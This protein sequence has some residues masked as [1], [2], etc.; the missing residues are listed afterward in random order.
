MKKNILLFILLVFNLTTW[1]QQKPNIIVIYA[2]DLGYGDLSCYGMSKI[3]TPNIDKLAKQG[4]Q[5]TNA[6]STSATCT[7]SR[8]GLL[9]G[10]YPW[11]QKGTGIAPG[12]ASLIIP[13]NKATLP[14]MLQKA[15]YTTAVIG[16]WHLGLGKNG[17]DWNKEI[18]PGPKEVG[19]DYSFIMP[20]TLDRVPCVYL[21]N[22]KVV[23]LDPKDPITVSY[24]EKVGNDPTGKENP[25]LL[26]M[27]PDPNQGHNETIVDSISRIGYMSGGHS[28]YWKDADIAGDITKKAISF[29]SKNAS[30]PFF[31]YFATGDIHVPRYPHS[32]FRGK[33]G[34]GLRG[35]AILQL[36]WTVGEIV[37]ALDSLKLS[38]NTLIIFSSDNGPV[39]N[40]GYM[41]KAVEML[42]SHKPAGPLRGGK[43]SAFEAGTRVPF[44]VKWP[45]SVQP[46]KKTSVLLS[47]VDLFSSLA[48]ITGQ[49]LQKEDALDSFDMSAQLTGKSKK[50]RS[51]L[52]EQGASLS[53]IQGKWKYIEP[54]NGPRVDHDVNIELGNDPK[55]QLYDLSKDIGEKINLASQYPEVVANLSALLKSSKELEITRP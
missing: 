46:D 55:P 20:A 38:Q 28:A 37:K 39:V 14:S 24:K 30:N 47:H 44:I 25:E 31:L 21:E 16:K 13:T 7:P 22:G 27:K 8:F 41:D 3:S 29:I 6:H 11:K 34:M 50:D 49:S 19:F 51:Y 17:I 5:F 48:K 9:T 40:D 1:A 2:D 33:S 26:R 52:I 35:D 18:K 32:M 53:I 45:A 36:D 15:G 4:L 43:Y 12:D 54:S 10:K 23:N 42:G